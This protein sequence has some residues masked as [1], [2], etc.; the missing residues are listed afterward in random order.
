ME[1]V[2]HMLITTVQTHADVNHQNQHSLKNKHFVLKLV[3]GAPQ[4]D[5][6]INL[7]NLLTVCTANT[8]TSK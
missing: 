8:Q 6:V 5:S 1:H 4:G 7:I 3:I 2:T